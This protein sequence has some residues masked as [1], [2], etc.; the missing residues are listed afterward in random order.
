VFDRAILSTDVCSAGECTC[1]AG[2]HQCYRKCARDIECAVGST[3]DTK[4]HVCVSAP[5]CTTNEQCAVLHASL[6]WE[7]NKTTGACGK[8]C[9]SDHDCSPSGHGTAG[10]NGSVC[11]A[12]G[13]CA[14]L[15]ADCTDDTQCAAPGLFGGSQMKTFCVD[16]PAVVAGGAVSSAIS[17]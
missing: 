15:G 13:F 14:L 1:Y 12:D 6:D 9:T 4:A 7:C 17:D 16:A 11:G 8:V 10:F 2:N 3:C 5:T